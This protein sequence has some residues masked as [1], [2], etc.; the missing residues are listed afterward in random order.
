MDQRKSRA[1]APDDPPSKALYYPH[2]EFPSTAW[3]KSALLYWDGVVRFHPPQSSPRDDAEIQ[4][5]LEAKV[6]ENVA[7]EPLRR[8]LV[9]ETVGPQIEE[10]VRAHGGRVPPRIPGLPPVRGAPAELEDRMLK[11]TLEDLH[12][13]PLAQ[14]ALSGERPQART[15]YLIFLVDRVAD[16]L[17]LAPATDDPLFDAIATYFAT[18]KVTEDPTKLTQGS[19]QGIAELCLPTP[20]LEAIAALPVKRLLD[21]RE[22]YAVQRR[23]FRKKVQ[24]QIATIAE[25]PTREAIEDHLETLRHKIHDDLETSRE[26]VED[27]KAKERWSLVGISAPVSVATGISIGAATSAALGPVG[28]AA[29]LALGVTSWFMRGRKATGAGQGHYLQQLDTAVSTPGEGMKRVL[30]GL[31]R[32]SHS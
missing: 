2:V 23:D 18:E 5:L 16:A 3:V 22:K 19:G 32:G 10:L 12:G 6:V 29:T 30:Q 4:E 20:S 25:L 9:T 11:E 24:A 13:Y 1:A 15:L 31:F 21:I 27:A 14:K 8:R 17:G 28:G 26:A 7:P